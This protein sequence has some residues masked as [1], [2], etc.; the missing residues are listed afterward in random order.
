MPSRALGR[1]VATLPAALASGAAEPV[2]RASQDIAD[3]VCRFFRAARVRVVVHRRR[4]HGEGGELHGLY[5]GGA[6]GRWDVVSLWMLTARR[7]QVVAFRT[8][9]RTL[10]HELCHHLDFTTL[11]LAESLHTPGFFRRES[12]LYDALLAADELTRP[13]TLPMTPVRSDEPQLSL[14]LAAGTP[15]PRTAGG[16]SGRDDGH[17]DDVARRG[18]RTRQRQRGAGEVLGKA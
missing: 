1:A 13:E 11:R 18:E 4:P 10:V 16:R 9:L 12:S 17:S 8:F 3:E 2:E 15:A 6:A 14:D 7:G 5:E